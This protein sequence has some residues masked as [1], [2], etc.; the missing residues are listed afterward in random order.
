MPMSWS[1][2]SVRSLARSTEPGHGP[3]DL[4]KAEIVGLPEPRLSYLRMNDPEAAGQ[5]LSGFY[6]VEQNAWRWM[7]EQ[8]AVV[9]QTPYHPTRFEMTFFLPDT[10]PARRITVAINGRVVAS[11]LY[12]GPGRY[13]LTVP[14]EVCG[15]AQVTVAVDQGFQA[16]GDPRRLGIIV[17]ELGLR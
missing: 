13:T 11:Q 14:V 6:D 8:G 1:V 10:A 5:L 7:G 17:Q 9:L 4:V 3:L 2:S 16:P 15:V 12:P